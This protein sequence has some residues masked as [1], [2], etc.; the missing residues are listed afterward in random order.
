M[1]AE[2]RPDPADG[3]PAIEAGEWADDKHGLLREYIDYCRGT[4]RRFAE[5]SGG[6]TYIELFAGPG[7]LFYKGT[8][9]FI[10]GSPLIAHK[11]AA[12]RS[13]PFSVMHLGDAR[14][15]FCAAV[16]A[17]LDR[18][19]ARAVM[20]PMRAEDS[21][22]VIVRALNPHGFNFAFIDPFGFD[23]L[24]F[25]IIETLAAFRR[26]DIIVHVSAMELQRKLPEYVDS[27]ECS[28]DRF[29]PG[30]RDAVRGL[31]PSDI[32]ARGKILEHWIKLIRKAGFEEA[33]GMPLIRGSK[34]QAL[35]WLAF[36]AKHELGRK[37]WDSIARRRE[38]NRNLF[39]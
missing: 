32:V 5:G 14:E 10:D 1:A 15:D 7:R 26:M 3:L 9:S 38:K 6:A 16:K 35:Y 20:Y 12:R 19:N 24:P 39:E 30:W 23:G 36:V 29:A 28:L 18:L 37:F 2:E 22:R 4:R 17:R 34:N 13:A 33:Q 25:S 27:S 21:A 8:G 11:E 31:N